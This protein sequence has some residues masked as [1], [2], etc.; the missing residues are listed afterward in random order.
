[1]VSYY[2]ED[3]CISFLKYSC[4]QYNSNYAIM[5]ISTL[6]NFDTNLGIVLKIIY[7]YIYIYICIHTYVC[8]YVYICMCTSKKLKNRKKNCKQ[9]VKKMY[10]LNFT[11]RINTF[12]TFI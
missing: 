5:N 1:M 2:D 4:I 6:L 11:K 8:M 9:K 7:K 3:M 10:V 12:C